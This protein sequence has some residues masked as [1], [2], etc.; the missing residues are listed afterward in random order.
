MI[1]FFI[2]ALLIMLVIALIGW[3]YENY[4]RK[5]QLLYLSETFKELQGQQQKAREK[6]KNQV[7]KNVLKGAELAFKM[8][9]QYVNYE[10]N[11]N[12]RG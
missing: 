12:E 9:R 8:A 11:P 2:I 5:M 7:N 1:Y 3:K 4:Q 6:E 10:L